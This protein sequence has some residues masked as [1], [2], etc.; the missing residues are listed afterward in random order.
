MLHDTAGERILAMDEEGIHCTVLSSVPPG[1]QS[2]RSAK[3]S[4]P[5]AASLNDQLAEIAYGRPGSKR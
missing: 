3:K 5:L 2:E 1:I 4:A